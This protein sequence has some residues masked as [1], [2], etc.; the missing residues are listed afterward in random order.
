M[1]YTNNEI[2]VPLLFRP[3]VLSTCCL[4]IKAQKTDCCD[5]II[6]F[7]LSSSIKVT[8]RKYW[9]HY[10]FKSIFQNVEH[11]FVF[12]DYDINH[13]MIA[14]SAIS[15]LSQN[16]QPKNSNVVLF[17]YTQC[18]LCAE[19]PLLILLCLLLSCQLCDILL[20]RAI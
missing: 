15:H 16:M 17:T 2:I 8:V 18:T 9:L 5:Q 7:A 3:S 12:N 19:Y 13:N 10:F 11:F 1:I 14:S 4:T 20:F 6:K